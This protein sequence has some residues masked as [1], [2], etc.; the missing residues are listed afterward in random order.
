MCSRSRDG[1]QTW[2]GDRLGAPYQLNRIGA[3]EERSKKEEVEES[4]S[5]DFSASRKVKLLRAYGGCL[6][7]KCRRRTWDTAK[8]LG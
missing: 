1:L 2:A 7:A 4:K 6:G 8:S 5:F 3:N